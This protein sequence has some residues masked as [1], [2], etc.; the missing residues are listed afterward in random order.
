M[1]IEVERKH[2]DSNSYRK[3]RPNGNSRSYTSTTIV[4]MNAY[5]ANSDRHRPLYLHRTIHKDGIHS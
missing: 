2:T 1:E 5:D 3:I 4:H